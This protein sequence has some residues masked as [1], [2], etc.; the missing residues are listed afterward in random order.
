V[1][2]VSVAQAS[3]HPPSAPVPPPALALVAR[4]VSVYNIIYDG[5]DG[6]PPNTGTGDA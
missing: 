5:Y 4:G 1:R 3:A 6:G 2:S